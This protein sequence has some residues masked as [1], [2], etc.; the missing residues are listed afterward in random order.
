[1]RAS[2]MERLGP[3]AASVDWSIVV[4]LYRSLELLPAQ[5]AALSAD[6][7]MARAELIL[8][9]DSP[10]QEDD[11]RR[12]L[13]GLGLI[14]GLSV[15]L[16]VNGRNLGYAGAVNAG[17]AHARGRWLVPLNSD[18]L[19]RRP[20]WLSALRRG[21]LPGIGAVGPLLLFPDDTIQ[22]AGLYY[23][24]GSDGA[25]LNRH[26]LKGLPRASAGALQPREVPGVTGACFV[27]ATETFHKLGGF[28]TDFAIGD[29]ED[30]DFCL[31]LR[32]AGLRLWYAP[33]AE[34]Y[35]L[36]RHSIQ[37]HAS[38]LRGVASRHNR[39]LHGRRWA[40]AMARLM[41]DPSRWALARRGDWRRSLLAAPDA[42]APAAADVSMVA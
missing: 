26:F 34:L 5:F 30:S 24:R 11:L 16:V 25:W 29:Y 27:V 40:A 4:P 22:H 10:E 41:D 28:C 1:M 19:P 17:A 7:D 35:H 33:E 31:R 14:Y 42:P 20:G 21:L 15:T 39:W 8:V 32:E 23:D 38:Y 18:V 37:Q 6:P 3:V 9:L 36:E 2:R 12:A 13:H